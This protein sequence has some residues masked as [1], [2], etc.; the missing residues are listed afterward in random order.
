MGSVDD[1]P[2]E[3]SD[4][5]VTDMPPPRASDWFWRPRYARLWWVSAGLFWIGAAIASLLAPQLLL[6]IG[7]GFFVLMMLFHPFVI[8]PVLGFGYALAWI[9]QNAIQGDGDTEGDS[10]WASYREDMFFGRMKWDPVGSLDPK[11]M[12][13]PLNPFSQAWLDQHVR[14]HS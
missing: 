10:D 4:N 8:L 7:G 11:H 14:P 6:Q 9:R 1:A 12:G 13:N 3:V 2:D 5:P